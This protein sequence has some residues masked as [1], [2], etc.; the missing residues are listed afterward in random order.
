M[1]LLDRARSVL[2]SMRCRFQQSE[3]EPSCLRRRNYLSVVIPLPGCRYTNMPPCRRRSIQ[4]TSHYFTSAYFTLD[5]EVDIDPASPSR[6][7]SIFTACSGL[8]SQWLLMGSENKLPL[9]H[10][11]TCPA[12]EIIPFRQPAFAAYRVALHQGSID[13]MPHCMQQLQ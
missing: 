5:R 11:R 8:L 1:N 3:P 9:L 12:L 6:P 7:L 4:S 2:M 10:Q 13:S